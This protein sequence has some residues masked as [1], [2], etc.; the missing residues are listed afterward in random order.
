M[1]VLSL[2]TARQMPRDIK[3]IVWPKWPW[4]VTFFSSLLHEHEAHCTVVE[5]GFWKDPCFMGHVV[6]TSYDMVVTTVK[7]SFFFKRDDPTLLLTGSNSITIPVFFQR[8]AGKIKAAGKWEESFRE[9][10][11]ILALFLDL[12]KLRR[13]TKQVLSY[14]II[15]PNSPGIV[16]H[17]TQKGDNPQEIK[18]LR[19]KIAVKV[20][21]VK[22]LTL[23][24]YG[25]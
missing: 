16:P 18:L 24:G 6:C 13:T 20:W 2:Q 22:L 9:D 21:R 1:P 7:M 14:L 10:S 4:S 19:V 5:T 3:G 23:D 15:K 11:A 8:T 12:A 25:S 17:G